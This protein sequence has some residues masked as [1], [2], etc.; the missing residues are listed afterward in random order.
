[1]A[2]DVKVNER[3]D[4]ATMSLKVKGLDAL[5]HALF[6][7]MLEEVGNAAREQAEAKGCAPHF[8]KAYEKVA[9]FCAAI[10]K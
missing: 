7:A 1:M 3:A 2:N 4:M 6:V 5:S 10:S 9:R 8:K